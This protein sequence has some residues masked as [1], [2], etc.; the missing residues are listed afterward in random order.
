MADDGHNSR[1]RDLVTDEGRS[2]FNYPAAYGGTPTGFTVT[3]EDG[4]IAFNRYPTGSR[5]ADLTVGCRVDL[6]MMGDTAA[7]ESKRRGRTDWSRNFD[8]APDGRFL[9]VRRTYVPAPCTIVMILGRR[10]GTLD[11]RR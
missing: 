4:A 7:V 8:V 5:K 3:L 10:A 6:V 2:T 11:S 9:M 1:R